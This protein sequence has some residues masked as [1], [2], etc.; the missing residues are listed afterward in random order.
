MKWYLIISLLIHMS[1]SASE[2]IPPY[3]ILKVFA[4]SEKTVKELSKHWALDHKAILKSGTY[5]TIDEA[6]QLL[7]NINP[8][9]LGKESDMSLAWLVDSN[10]GKVEIL[11][12]ALNLKSELGPGM[13]YKIISVKKK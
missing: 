13:M 2:I 5:K 7:K 9:T 1:A 4:G 3:F 12:K 8:K 10:G 6:V 11:F